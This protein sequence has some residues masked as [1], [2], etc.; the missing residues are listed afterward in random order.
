MSDE[1][2]LLWVPLTPEEWAAL[3]AGKSLTMLVPAPIS[4][5]TGKPNGKDTLLLIQPPDFF[6]HED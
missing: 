2:H 1:P 3:K 4:A 5:L 6:P